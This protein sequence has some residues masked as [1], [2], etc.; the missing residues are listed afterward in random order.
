MLVC[1]KAGAATSI[2]GPK[3]SFHLNSDSVWCLPVPQT[4]KQNGCG[5]FVSSLSSNTCK[6]RLFAADFDAECVNVSWT[7][8]T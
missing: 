7:H 3:A 8:A 6:C 4:G 1:S 2:P 5:Q